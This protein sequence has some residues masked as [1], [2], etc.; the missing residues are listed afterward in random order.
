MLNNWRHRQS[1]CHAGVV[2]FENSSGT[3][4]QSR[5]KGSKKANKGIKP[6][7]SNW[8]MSAMRYNTHFKTYYERKLKEGKNKF[9]VFNAMKNNRGGG[10]FG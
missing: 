5:P 3:S 8:V 6:T 4:L 1:D 7:L 2:P 10:P 9:T